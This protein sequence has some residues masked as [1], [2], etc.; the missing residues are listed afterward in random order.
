M[1]LSI[2]QFERIPSIGAI[3]GTQGH[4]DVLDSLNNQLGSSAFF[5]SSADPFAEQ[6]KYFIDRVVEPIRMIGTQFKAQFGEMLNKHENVIRPIESIKDLEYG[7]PECMW[8]PI[9]MHPTIKKLGEQRR[10]D[11]FGMKP[12]DIPDE[13]PYLR[14]I[15]NGVDIDLD[16]AKELGDDYTY[17]IEVRTDDPVL[18]DEELDYIEDTYNFIDLFYNGLDKLYDSIGKKSELTSKS[19]MDEDTVISDLDFTS[20]P[21]KKG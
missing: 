14:L 19:Y 21:D 8:M 10:I 13:N 9:A 11:L 15:N 6:Q 2:M 4:R 20:F 3:L 5:G 12:T 18:T 7:I 17:T 16:K 1:S